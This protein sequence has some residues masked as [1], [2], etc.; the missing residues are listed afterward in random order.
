MANQGVKNKAGPEAR[1]IASIGV[2]VFSWLSPDY[3]ERNHSREIQSS[4]IC[5]WT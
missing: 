5:R 4:H 3:L 1:L 2:T